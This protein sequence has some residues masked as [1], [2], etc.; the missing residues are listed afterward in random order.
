MAVAL[1]IIAVVLII[2]GT[3]ALV[4][5]ADYYNIN[6]CGIFSD[7]KHEERIREFERTVDKLED[8]INGTVQ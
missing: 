1:T 6:R 3:I 8:K 5:Y 4:S 2:C 7:P